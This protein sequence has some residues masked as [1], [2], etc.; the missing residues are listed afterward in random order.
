MMMR[1]F[2]IFLTLSF[3]LVTCLG[4]EE[5]EYKEVEV[6]WEE[7]YNGEKLPESFQIRLPI[8]ENK[9]V[10]LDLEKKKDRMDDVMVI[11]ASDGEDTVWK[12][13]EEESFSLYSDNDYHASFSVARNKSIHGRL[14]IFG[15]YRIGNREYSIRPDD[16][17]FDRK[18]LDLNSLQEFFIS[19]R[20]H[21]HLLTEDKPVDRSKHTGKDYIYAD[22]L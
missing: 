7:E 6:E 10:L 19:I 13:K 1:I 20:G 2:Q 12:P 8:D 14:T 15:S 4:Q 17:D 11:V 9:T 18:A 16:S 22:E 3:S 21:R 5:I